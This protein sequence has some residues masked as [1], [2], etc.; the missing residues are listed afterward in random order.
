MQ[1]TDWT[2][3][4]LR[5]LVARNKNHFRQALSKEI[6]TLRD[7][8]E[9][10]VAQW[11]KLQMALIPS[12][13]AH[14]NKQAGCPVEKELLGLPSQLSV[15]ER[16][17]LK[18][19]ALENEEANLREGAIVDALTSVKLVVQSCLS[20]KDRKKKNSSGVYKNTISQK[21]IV[22]AE[23]RRDLHIAKYMA[24]R[25]ALISLGRADGVDDYPPLE[26]KDTALKSRS[27]RRQLGDSQITE[28]A[29]WAQGGIGVGARVV[30]VPSTSAAPPPLPDSHPTET[31]MVRR[32]RRPGA[33]LQATR[34][35]AT[36]SKVRV[37]TAPKPT[38]KEGWLWSFKVGKMTD[39]ELREWTLEGIYR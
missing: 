13:Q 8:I 17:E 14:L 11:R 32:A 31:Q 9:N 18:L 19:S 21:Q 30:G 36:T 25:E 22:D 26:V 35:Q 37:S 3:L 1:L 6:E 20:L 23:R 10:S 33:K 24:A 29:V 38:R 12:M 28:G 16:L 2:R 34:S 39:E 5:K 27:L 7:S 4:R 15:A